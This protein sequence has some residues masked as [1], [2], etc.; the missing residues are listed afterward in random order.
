MQVTDLMVVLVEFGLAVVVIV[1]VPGAQLKYVREGGEEE[2]K[3][4]QNQFLGSTVSDEERQQPQDLDLDQLYYE[5]H[6]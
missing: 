3:H 1:V 6:G 4:L 5:D 2:Q